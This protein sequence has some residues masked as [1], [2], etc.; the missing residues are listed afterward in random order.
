MAFL[1]NHP[2][3][4]MRD[5]AAASLDRLEAD[6]GVISVNRAGVT[7]EEQQRVI[8]RWNE[9][10]PANRPPFLYEPRRPP[11]DSEHV[12]NGGCAFDTDHQSLMLSVGPAYGF[13][14]TFDWDLPHFVYDPA[15]DT[16]RPSSGLTPPP[17]PL[18]WGWYFG[19]ASGPTESVSGYYGHGDDLAVF[20]RRM[21]ERGWD[22]GQWGADGRYGDVLGNVTEAFQREKGLKPDRLIGPA[23]WAAAWTEPVT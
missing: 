13:F 9:G 4:W 19:P 2:G 10:G 17:F 1:T 8:D 15:R 23:T 5:D 22:L 18:P 20:Q 21:I 3:Q 6:H 7:V 11:E 14:R 12:K 16:K